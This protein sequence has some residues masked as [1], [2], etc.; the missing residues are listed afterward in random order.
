MIGTPSRTSTLGRMDQTDRVDQGRMNQTGNADQGHR[1]TPAKESP[2]RH[3]DSPWKESTHGAH[4]ARTTR[5]DNP[6]KSALDLPPVRTSGVRR[7]IEQA[8]LGIE[9]ESGRPAGD[10]PVTLLCRRAHVARSTFYANYRT[11]DDVQRA[12]ELR[13]LHTIIDD[14]STLTGTGTDGA[15]EAFGR[16]AALVEDNSTLFR[17]LVVD[18][19]A[20]RFLPDW[21]QALCAHLWDRLFGRRTPGAT[22]SHRLPSAVNRRLMVEM[23][24]G[25]M[26]SFVTYRLEHPGE[27]S[28]EEIDA[29][30]PR[31]IAALDEIW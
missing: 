22:P 28:M 9:R 17:L 18:V 19:P 7:A 10:I 8:L 25:V 24:A 1:H 27:V 6:Y 2:G 23:A 16:V 3:S 13:L 12:V 30:L 5:T 15:I 21:K 4:N 26:I 14:G 29:L 31:L 11:T 20:E